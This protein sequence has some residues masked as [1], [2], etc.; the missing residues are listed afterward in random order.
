MPLATDEQVLAAAAAAARAG[1]LGR[2]HAAGALPGHHPRHRAPARAR[3]ERRTRDD[4]RRQGKPLAESR[5]EVLLSLAD[6]IDFLAEEGKRAYGRLVPPRTPGWS[7]RW[8]ARCLSGRPALFT[9][10]ASR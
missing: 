3:R 6:I 9:P 7:R 1:R 5:R 2:E 10:W 4:A 8:S